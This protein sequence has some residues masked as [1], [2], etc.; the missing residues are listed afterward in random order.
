M[1]GAKIDSA[2]LDIGDIQAERLGLLINPK[3]SKAYGNQYV[4]I[5][6]TGNGSYL[7]I[8]NFIN[9]EIKNANCIVSKSGIT[10]PTPQASKTPK[11]N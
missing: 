11:N 10:T 7:E 2:I 1:K 6:R 4:L 9:C 5:P 3:I 8:Q